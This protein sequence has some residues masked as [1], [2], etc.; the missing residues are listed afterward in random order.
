MRSLREIRYITGSVISDFS[1]GVIQTATTNPIAVVVAATAAAV[2]YTGEM[3]TATLTLGS[4]ALIMSGINQALEGINRNAAAVAFVKAELNPADE[5]DLG[6]LPAL[7]VSFGHQPNTFASTATAAASTPAA[8][9]SA[10]PPVDLKL[11]VE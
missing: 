1:R 2:A 5:K 10:I 7:V 4:S 3:P 6:P 11:H 8:S 9:G